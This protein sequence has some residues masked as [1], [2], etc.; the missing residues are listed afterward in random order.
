M[1]KQRLDDMAIFGIK[2]L[3]SRARK[4]CLN[5]IEDGLFEK[6]NSQGF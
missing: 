1:M 3:L 5:A 4:L 2:S 6:A